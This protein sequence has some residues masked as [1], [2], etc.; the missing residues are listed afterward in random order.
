MQLSFDKQSGQMKWAKKTDMCL[1]VKAQG[2]S[3]SLQRC[4][5]TPDEAFMIATKATKSPEG[6]KMPLSTPGVL[7]GDA[8]D[9]KQQDESTKSSMLRDGRKQASLSVG[10]T[11]SLAKQKDDNKTTST[12][13]KAFAVSGLGHGSSNANATTNTNDTLNWLEELQDLQ[14]ENRRLRKHVAAPWLPQRDSIATTQ[15]TSNG[16]E[17]GSVSVPMPP[18][19]RDPLN[20]T[21]ATDEDDPLHTGIH[22]HHHIHQ[23][24]HIHHPPIYHHHEH[25]PYH[26]YHH[27]HYP[28]HPY[29]HPYHH[30]HYEHDMEHMMSEA[31]DEAGTLSGLL[32]TQEMHEEAMAEH[33]KGLEEES[34]HNSKTLSA[35]RDHV[36][37]IDKEL[38]TMEHD[39]HEDIEEEEEEEEEH[40]NHEHHH[41]GYH[42][43]HHEE[44]EHYG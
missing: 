32:R 24:H 21:N 26:P 16:V 15:N 13:P 4:R 39:E 34:F 14:K 1:H 29:H 3:G 33:I 7:A 44:G 17:S 28:Y 30:E 22:I 25:H 37:E 9:P 5:G 42:E 41:Y 11:G 8:K 43:D 20:V 18:H 35:I 36:H 27:E 40:N 38:M 23:V 10:P 31:D 12:V 2:S 6:S 19:L